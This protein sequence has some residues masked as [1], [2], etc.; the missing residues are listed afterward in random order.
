MCLYGA[1]QVAECRMKQGQSPKN[2]NTDQSM[3]E[4]KKITAP[5]ES[6]QNFIQFEK[7]IHLNRRSDA[8]V[9]TS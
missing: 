9:M 6:S 3:H 4:K 5:L 8:Q 7:K 2:G 1:F